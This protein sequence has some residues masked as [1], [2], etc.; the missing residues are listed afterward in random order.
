MQSLL[1]NSCSSS[2][3]LHR[4]RHAVTHTHIR[5]RAGPGLV[6]VFILLCY[7]YMLFISADCGDP[8]TFFA[9]IHTLSF[10]F[11]IIINIIEGTKLDN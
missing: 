2:S 7:Y 3:V 8:T 9:I 6:V 10:K 5:G 11:I 1:N 4:V